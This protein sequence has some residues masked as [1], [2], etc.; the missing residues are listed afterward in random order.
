MAKIFLLLLNNIINNVIY[1]ILFALK[2]A[3]TLL[4]E[5]KFC[6]IIAVYHFCRARRLK[7]FQKSIFHGS[8]RCVENLT[9]GGG[10][11]H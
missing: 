5:I 2:A 7:A 1:T 4:Q 10:G 6:A 8:V 9:E 11:G 3:H